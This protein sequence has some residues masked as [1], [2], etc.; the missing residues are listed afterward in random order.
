MLTASA[1]QTK[2]HRFGVAE[3]NVC[4]GRFERIRAGAA[5]PGK[6][7]AL[8]CACRQGNPSQ[9]NGH[10]LAWITARPP[11]VVQRDDG[12][13]AYQLGVFAIHKYEERGNRSIS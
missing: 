5:F 9:F 4:G 3:N 7:P 2:E 11:H 1:G 10:E 13:H 6:F 12:N 8:V